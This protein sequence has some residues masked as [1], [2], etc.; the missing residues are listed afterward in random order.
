MTNDMVW[1]TRRLRTAKEQNRMTNEGGVRLTVPHFLH[2]VLPV[3]SLMKSCGYC[4][5]SNSQAMYER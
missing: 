5:D 3:Y 4:L 2:Y 1:P